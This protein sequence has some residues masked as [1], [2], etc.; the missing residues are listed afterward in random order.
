MKKVI[1]SGNK[2]YG[3]GECLY[4]VFPDATFCSRSNGSYDLTD[5]EQMGTFVSKSMDYD[6]YIGCSYLPIFAQTILLAKLFK[7]WSNV[8]KKG[9]IIVVGSTADWSTKARFYS[10]EKK[11]LRD[12]S[13]RMAGLC[14]G[15]GPQLY[16]GN[17]LRITY[18]APGMI[19]LPKQRQKHGNDLAMVDP[20]YIA[21]TIK[22]LTEQPENINIHEISMDPVQY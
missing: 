12:F 21:N 20:M 3:L 9:Q 6:V 18:V 14:T 16:P 15:G 5:Q 19:D 1:I 13:R 8:K 10:T 17:G 7:E 4:K 11:A 22:W 2:H